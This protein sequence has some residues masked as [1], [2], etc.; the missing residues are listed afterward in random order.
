MSRPSVSL[1][2]IVRNE[3]DNLRPCL[4][5]VR[6]LCDEVV[7]V[8]TGSTD[9]SREVAA[10]LG[11]RVVDFEWCD[12]FSAARNESLGHATGDWIFWM[13]ADD[14]LDQVNVQRLGELF[15]QVGARERAY[16][17]PCISLPQ[18]PVDPVIVLPHCRL[19]R[20]H[21]Q[22]RWQRR[23]H[24]Q[25]VPTIE[26]LGHEIV[27]A[28]VEIT[29]VGYSD[30]AQMRRK[31]NRDLRL[32]RMD[33]AT[34][35]TDSGTLF[36]LGMVNLRL[37]QNSEALTYLLAC[38]KYNTSSGD[39]VRRL[40]SSLAE[41][42][43]R[44]AR[45]EEALGM[46]AEGLTRFPD[47]AALL[48]LRAALLSQMG[49]L[50]GAER[51]LL[52]LLRTPPRP[53]LP[54]EKSVLDFREGRS[55][56]GLIYS[57]Q[58]RFREAERVFQELLAQYPEYIQAWV[59]LGY[60]YLGKGWFHEAEYVA[61]QVEKCPCGEAYA[62]ALRAEAC[63]RRGEMAPARQ[64]LDRAIAAAPNMVWPRIVLGEWLLKSGASLADCIAAQRDILRMHPQNVQA[65]NNLEALQRQ[66]QA[67]ATMSPDWFQ[68]NI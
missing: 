12:D 53:L 50:G 44:L 15:R 6:N 27:D 62:A 19:F 8:D 47:D 23:V 26:R 46:L 35:P 36:N 34:D 54:G 30:A 67:G 32:L 68:F 17:M 2:M 51:C 14:R 64:F 41:A 24:E 45:R 48:T 60:L 59:G 22:I 39:W 10:S 37:G 13:D 61:N 63:I 21:P 52:Q 55:L 42:L 38:L 18:Y 58:G 4:E 31:I 66:E 5:P 9:T 49:D 40:Y 25:V 16:M 11:A 56:L 7:V 20:R 57:E 1:C 65:A 28:N 3:A 43:N 29:H 33:Y